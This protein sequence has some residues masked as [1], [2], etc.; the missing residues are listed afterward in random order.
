MEPLQLLLRF[1]QRAWVV[2][3]VT[4][5]VREKGQK[6]QVNADLPARWVMH[7]CAGC[8][9][10]ELDVVAI[11]AMH[12]PH[13]LDLLQRK[14]FDVLLTIAHEPQAS[15]NLICFPSASNFQPVC[16]YSTERLSCW[17]FG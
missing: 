8:L 10:P 16:L 9:Y 1:S 15:V 12:Y 4:F 3:R 5:R 7:D 11:G 6:T 17:N 14:G 13:P 2:Y